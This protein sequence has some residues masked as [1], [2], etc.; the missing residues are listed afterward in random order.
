MNIRLCLL[1]LLL[2]VAAPAFS[3]PSQPSLPEW[4]QLTPAQRETL[5][6]PMRDRWNASP[7]HRQRMYEHARG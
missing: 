5:I 6:A 3:Q 1:P 2:A 7:E 4:D